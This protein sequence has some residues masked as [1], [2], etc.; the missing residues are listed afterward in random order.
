MLFVC[1]NPETVGSETGGGNA[2]SLKTGTLNITLKFN[3]PLHD[4][5]DERKRA[6]L[7][8]GTRFHFNWVR[9]EAVVVSF[10]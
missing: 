6:A 7:G 4:V 3:H 5:R 10:G 1:W 2:V 8:D 9:N